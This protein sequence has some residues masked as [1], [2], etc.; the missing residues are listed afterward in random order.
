MK[1][2]ETMGMEGIL[3]STS[4]SGGDAMTTCS[5]RP[6]Q[7]EGGSLHK[8]SHHMQKQN[9]TGIHHNA[10]GIPNGKLKKKSI[11]LA[12]CRNRLQQAYISC[13]LSTCVK[14]TR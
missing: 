13:A 9:G 1:G 8:N 12:S 10:T 7:P 14:N 4:R 11:S 5:S 6:H 3:S 2:G